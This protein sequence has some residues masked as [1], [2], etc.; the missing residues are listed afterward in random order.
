MTR[1][2][3]RIAILA[4]LACACSTPEQAPRDRAPATWNLPPLPAFGLRFKPRTPI[5]WYQQL[6]PELYQRLRSR[7]SQFSM[8]LKHATDPRPKIE[9]AGRL[10]TR[11]QFVLYSE[12]GKTSIKNETLALPEARGLQILWI[13]NQPRQEGLTR[14][15]MCA[16][17]GNLPGAFFDEMEVDPLRWPDG[18][19]P[20]VL[21]LTPPPFE[22]KDWDEA[23]QVPILDRIYGAVDFVLNQVHTGRHSYSPERLKERMKR[24]LDFAMRGSP[25]MILSRGP[26]DPQAVFRIIPGNGHSS[27]DG[28]I[29]VDGYS[30]RDPAN[31]EELEIELEY[32]DF[33]PPER[34]M[35]IPIYELGRLG[36]RR[37]PGEKPLGPHVLDNFYR[38]ASRFIYLDLPRKT[39][40]GQLVHSGMAGENKIVHG[41]IY[42]SASPA[43]LKLHMA[44]YGKT[45]WTGTKKLRERGWELVRGPSNDADRISIIKIS[46]EDYFFRHPHGVEDLPVEPGSGSTSVQTP[47]VAPFWTGSP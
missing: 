41:V 7:P 19:G 21:G 12:D 4:L 9:A 34:K 14:F 38:E 40:S 28:G 18:K 15:V 39:P 33:V 10:W 42:A 25:Y 22:P 26:K 6:R 2:V 16:Q 31:V 27:P 35:G 24:E 20:G 11:S 8:V 47:L 45:D 3:P 46:T 1:S 44:A 13:R 30:Y 23:R 29:F 32:P 17:D 43:M 5:E 37:A 36:K